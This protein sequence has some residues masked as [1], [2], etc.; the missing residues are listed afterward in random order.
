MVSCARWPL[1][2]GHLVRLIII[3]AIN[4]FVKKNLFAGVMI[5]ETLSLR[6]PFDGASTVDL[7]RA[8]LNDPPNM[9]LLPEGVYSPDIYEVIEGMKAFNGL[10]FLCDECLVLCCR[11]LDERS[12]IEIHCS[13]CLKTSIYA[14]KGQYANFSFAT[15]S[16]SSYHDRWLLFLV[17]TDRNI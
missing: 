13:R 6:L 9:S 8:I 14:R 17:S 1:I 10:C 12:K 15:L 7:V 16:L 3:C 5:F 4:V 2:T 11:M